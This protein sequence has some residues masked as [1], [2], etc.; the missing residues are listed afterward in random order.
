MSLWING[1]GLSNAVTGE[2]II[3]I[4]SIFNLDN[5]KEDGDILKIKFRIYPDGSKD[6]YVEINPFSK[7]FVYK[8]QTFPIADFYKTFTGRN[9]G[10]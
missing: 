9:F 1:F 7:S 10:K 3:P 2:E 6:Y 8:N 4:I 5:I